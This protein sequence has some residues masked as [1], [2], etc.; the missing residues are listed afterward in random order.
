MGTFFITP[1]SS[2]YTNILIYR[3]KMGK[4]KPKSLEAQQKNSDKYNYVIIIEEM[5]QNP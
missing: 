4:L 2:S 1:T 5:L 3:C